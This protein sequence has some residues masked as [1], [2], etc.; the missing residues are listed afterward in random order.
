MTAPEIL[1]VSEVF[2]PSTP[3]KVG[4]I[5]RA[6]I[7]D[8]L[9]NA[10]K[11]PG[12]QIVVYGHSG[13]GKTS[14]LEN[15]L[16]ETYEHHITTRCM[17]GMKFDDLII[18]A[19]DQLEPF[20]V[21][22][23][24]G[25]SKSELSASYSAF[26]TQIGGVFSTEISAE[27][28]R[29]LSPQINPQT[30]G[31]FLGSA[32]ACWVLEDFHKIDNSEKTKL[33]QMM[34]IFMDMSCDFP[35]LKII[36]LGATDTA[37]QVIEY[38]NEMRNRVAEIHVP[39]MTSEEIKKVIKKGEGLLNV[40]FSPNTIVGISKIS[41]GIAAVCHN[42]CL[43]M[44][45]SAGIT[46]TFTDK[47]PF[48]IENEHYK[49]AIDNYIEEASDTIKMTFEKALKLPRSGVNNAEIILQA[50]SQLKEEG[51]A[52]R[53]LLAKIKLD[54]KSYTDNR[55]KS[56]LDKLC[57]KERG[58]AIRYNQN[59]GVYSFSEPVFRA[60]AL[61]MVHKKGELH[62]KKLQETPVDIRKV[63]IRILEESLRVGSENSAVD[64]ILT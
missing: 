20:Y 36:A 12:K 49:K 64:E 25:T 29:I 15:K 17:T 61:S 43:Q 8:R 2:T 42:L 37:R 33:A 6:E 55:L 26:K 28:R 51:V 39:L 38:D 4:F 21:S 31:K 16:I 34:K 58:A 53:E 50:L 3:A 14:L 44:C 52:R 32:K 24:L 59:S 60:Y 13:N 48:H 10:L 11:T 54:H 9:V 57:T 19:F 62:T 40:R 45:Y 46:S 63:L 35:D 1:Q 41:N 23:S 7:N 22:S 27:K 18:N 30:L 47:I 56:H 5:D